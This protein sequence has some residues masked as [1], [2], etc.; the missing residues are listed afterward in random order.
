MC[1]L[2][3]PTQPALTETMSVTPGAMAGRQRYCHR[4]AGLAMSLMAL[5]LNGTPTHAQPTPVMVARQVDLSSLHARSIATSSQLITS[6]GTTQ[7]PNKG[8]VALA[9][10]Q[11]I[12]QRLDIPV[13]L[14]VSSRQLRLQLPYHFVMPDSRPGAAPNATLQL[15]LM[16]IVD[17]G[18]MHFNPAL[19]KFVGRLLVG[20]TDSLDQHH[21]LP[22]PQPVAILLAGEPTEKEPA[23]F[24]LTATNIDAVQAIELRERAPEDSL[25]LRI[26]PTF[27][28]EGVEVTIP[29]KKQA[30][31]VDPE[32]LHVA[33]FGLGV[34][35]LSVTLPA[36]I[37][38]DGPVQFTSDLGDLKPR[39][40][41]SGTRALN[42]TL[43]S[44]GV[45]HTVFRAKLQPFRTGRALVVFDWPTWFIGAAL[46][47]GAL[48]AIAESLLRKRR[49][50]QPSWVKPAISGMIVG[51]VLAVAY[52]GG[53][54]LIPTEIV[55]GASVNEAV[56][57][58]IAAVGG[59]FGMPLLKQQI[60]G[61]R[62]AQDEKDS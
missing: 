12:V 18:G 25:V 19:G 20:V 61:L 1:A 31:I 48:G 45:G 30:V 2:K 41:P 33:G 7:L 58:V 57:F 55:A 36:G 26:I 35:Q 17:G 29:V 27:D 9:N 43:R 10:H 37:R 44:V 34:A 13:R 52:A 23:S 47:G 4:R 40:A 59:A 6:V 21:S 50:N 15:G 22:L 32:T 54:Q 5:T 62:E 42:V 49:R 24:R 16:V 11:L 38:P 46:L 53:M 14:S 60:P 39:S 56:I 28:P 51:L 3:R 8:T